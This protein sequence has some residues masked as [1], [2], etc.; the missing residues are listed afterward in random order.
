MRLKVLSC[1]LLAGLLCGSGLGTGAPVRAEN[2]AFMYFTDASNAPQNPPEQRFPN[3]GWFTIGPGGEFPSFT[4]A[5]THL[6]SLEVIGIGGFHFEVPA[7]TVFNEN[8]PTITRVASQ[9]S[10]VNF[11][12]VGTGPNPIIRATGTAEEDDWIIRLNGVHYYTFDGIDVA[13]YGSSTAI[14]YGYYLTT[15]QGRACGYN[16]IKNCYITLSS[17]NANSKGIYANCGT[18][19]RHYYNNY[20]NIVI[21]GVNYG[22]HLQGNESQYHLGELISSCAISNANR[23]G[24]LCPFGEGTVIENNWVSVRSGSMDPFE[25]ISFGGANSSAIVNGNNVAGAVTQNTMTGILQSLGSGTISGNTI[26]NATVSNYPVTGIR[27]DGGSAVVSGNTVRNLSSNRSVTGIRIAGETS[28]ASVERNLIHS[29]ANTSTSTTAFYCSG[30]E[31]GGINTLLANNMLHSITAAS[32]TA[33]GVRGISTLAGSSLRIIYNS[34]SLNAPAVHSSFSSAALYI[35]EAN[36]SIELIN[37][38]FVNLSPPG[39]GTLGR[40]VAMWKDAAGFADLSTGSNNNIY[41][42]GAPDAKRLIVYAGGVGYQ[43]LI[44]Y[45]FVSGGRDT[46]SYQEAVP[47]MASN[48]LHIQQNVSTN[49]EG[50]ALP[51]IGIDTDFDGDQRNAT[52]PDIGADEGYFGEANVSVSPGFAN[53]GYVCSD[54][55]PGAMS[56]LISNGSMSSTLSFS[57]GDFSI[58]GPDFGSFALVDL[59]TSFVLQPQ[60]SQL[61]SLAFTPLGYGVRQ[62]LLTISNGSFDSLEI[63]LY[64][65]GTLAASAPLLSNWEAGWE[66]WIAVNSGLHNAWN[67]GSAC[68]YRDS[69]A[70]YISNDG[71]LSHGYN[72]NLASTVHAFLDVF[73]PQS[74]PRLLFNWLCGGNAADRMSIRI[75]PTNISPQALSLPN[76]VQLGSDLYGQTQW[77]YAELPIPQEYAGQLVRLVLSWQ[78][79]YTTISQPPAAIDNL[80]ILGTP[81]PPSA[82]QNP[83]LQ[84]ASGALELSW[85]EAPGANE[86]LLE[87]SQSPDAGFVQLRR[88]AGSACVIYDQQPKGFF[89]VRALE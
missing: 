52:H 38:I 18:G 71:G 72:G 6:N 20:Q 10:P 69:A 45:Q 87:A 31:A 32:N 46:A 83:V 88:L 7:G 89:R 80:R 50:K 56:L 75:M 62:A 79:N 24:I 78:N 37:N 40:T 33:P 11:E 64:G 28:S 8:P 74:N 4:A 68:A 65:S 44:G 82:P 35:P 34:I 61:L 60:Q 70:L 39:S 43:N 47:F 81:T 42:A 9:A 21:S 55:A 73:L 13:N 2:G 27:I 67:I 17:A 12:K 53:F 86:Y 16:T 15:S 25:G 36:N 48:N 77:Q 59:P 3:S 49:V 76:G 84:M 19:A 66:G 57:A 30:I 23:Y 85:A 26:R 5:I 14:E 29:L 54:G 63:P 41:W 51:I 1:C 22:I 58:T